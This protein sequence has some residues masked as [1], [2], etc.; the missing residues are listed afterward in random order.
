MLA[1]VW[2]L[3]RSSSIGHYLRWDT[4]PRI[5]I[6]SAARAYNNAF[7]LTL[8]SRTLTC[9]FPVEDEQ[10]NPDVFEEPSNDYILVN[11]EAPASSPPILEVIEQKLPKFLPKPDSNNQD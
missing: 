3:V 2:T 4:V 5:S 8:P 1:N 11:K 7:G 6:N 10:V 9:T